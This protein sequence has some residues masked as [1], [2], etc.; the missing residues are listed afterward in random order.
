[1]EGKSGHLSLEDLAKLLAGDLSHE[2]L[3]TRVIPHFLELCPVCRERHE[4]IL[5]LQEEL[6]HWDERVVVMEGRQAPELLARL[7]KHRFDEQVRL[8]MNDDALHTWGLAQLLLKES[9]EAAAPDPAKATDLAELAVKVSQSLGEAYDPHW[10]LD[11]QA[12]AYAY[13]GHARRLLGEPR[14]AES[15]F[16][17]AEA[18]L[19]RSMTGNAEI[20]AEV[21]QLKADAG[22]SDSP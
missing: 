19:A 2:D 6:G 11:L 13:L 21:R 8:V 18:L 17:E 22:S 9:R 20:Q 14:S 16:R 3:L 7:R 4:E 12:R 1:M 15:A 5:R 10:V